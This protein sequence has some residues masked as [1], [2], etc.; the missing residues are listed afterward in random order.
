[1]MKTN[2]SYASE[3]VGCI[4]DNNMDA[5][6]M[7]RYV[8]N[9]LDQR[10]ADF[11]ERQREDNA[12]EVEARVGDPV[13]LGRVVVLEQRLANLEKSAVHKHDIEYACSAFAKSIRR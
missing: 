4:L 7:Q 1:M 10:D 9:M 8:A 13:L 11:K 12:N 2:D 6:K 3:I 5:D